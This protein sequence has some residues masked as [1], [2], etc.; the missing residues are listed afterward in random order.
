MEVVDSIRMLGLKRPIKVN[1]MIG[2][3]GE[4]SYGLA[5]GPGR[6]EAFRELGHTEI[7]A[8]VTGASEQDCLVMSLVE[9]CARRQHSPPA[10]LLDGAPYPNRGEPRHHQP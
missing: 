3:D 10:I 9:N 8:I 6:I 4:P 5:C 1:T 2:S 7:P